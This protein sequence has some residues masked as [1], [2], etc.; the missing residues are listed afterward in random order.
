MTDKWDNILTN[1]INNNWRGKYF[2]IP[3]N[4]TW[5]WFN[6]S[7]DILYLMVRFLYHQAYWGQEGSLFYEII[8]YNGLIIATVLSL[9]WVVLVIIMAVYDDLKKWWE[10]HKED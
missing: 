5:K 8:F 2:G 6:I 4:N 10:R 3:M 7:L 1:Y 9:H